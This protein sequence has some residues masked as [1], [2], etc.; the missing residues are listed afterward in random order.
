MIRLAKIDDIDTI[1]KIDRQ[2]F[3]GNKPVGL[4]EEWYMENLKRDNTYYIFVYEKDG[5]VLGYITWELKGGLARET[6]VV[7]LDKLAVHTEYRGQGIGTRLVEESFKKIK[8]IIADKH[9]KAGKIRVFV[10]A[11]KDNQAA[12]ASYKKICSNVLGERNLF[13]SDEIM[14]IGDHTL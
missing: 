6:P 9:K 11:K 13:G 12:V 8:N 2:S 1:A 3:S 14:L 4:A 10:W 7:E 5:E